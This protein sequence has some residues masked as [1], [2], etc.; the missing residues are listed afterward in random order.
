MGSKDHWSGWVDFQFG[1]NFCIQK[2]FS[3]CRYVYKQVNPDLYTW[4]KTDFQSHFSWLSIWIQDLIKRKSMPKN[5]FSSTSSPSKQSGNKSRMRENE[6][7]SRFFTECRS[8]L[9]CKTSSWTWRSV[10][11]WLILMTQLY[12]IWN[13]NCPQF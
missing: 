2:F 10:D 6:F 3:F 12:N 8:R 13:W 7:Q 9:N 11:S 4:N 5:Q 1:L